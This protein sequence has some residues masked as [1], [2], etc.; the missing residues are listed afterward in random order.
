MFIPN[1]PSQRFRSNGATL[2]VPLPGNSKIF[3]F[4]F[5]EWPKK[6]PQITGLLS[7]KRDLANQRYFC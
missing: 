3:T 5:Y 2:K 4:L 6:Y 7:V 1:R